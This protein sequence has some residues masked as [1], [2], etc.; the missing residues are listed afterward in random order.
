MI[1]SF[2]DY[3][4]KISENM[5]KNEF[6]LYRGQHSCKWGLDHTFSRFCKNN[7]ETFE[8]KHFNNILAE[9]INEASCFLEKDLMNNLD[10]LQSVALAQHYGLPTPFLDWTDSP[11]IA[12]FFAISNRAIKDIEPFRIWALKISKT[13]DYYLQKANSSDIINDFYIVNTSFFY[14]KRLKRQ[15]GYFSYLNNDKPL[16]IFLKDNR[17]GIKL[18]YYDI[19]GTSWLSIIKELSLMGISHN[20]LYDNLDGI[21][22]D[23]SLDFLYNRKV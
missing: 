18:T 2:N 6:W 3:K 1:I 14:S 12:A 23:V 15:R 19:N 5:N 16:D 8:I 7:E 10:Y 20:S 21:A 13:A 11:Y 4:K 22:T 17:Y 9:F